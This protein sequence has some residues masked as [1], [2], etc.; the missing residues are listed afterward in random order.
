MGILN[1]WKF[2]RNTENEFNINI[3]YREKMT[4][5]DLWGDTYVRDVSAY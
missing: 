3:V 2:P 5:G 1:L 4:R